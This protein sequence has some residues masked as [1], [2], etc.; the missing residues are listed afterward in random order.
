MDR[1]FFW[2]GSLFGLS[3]AWIPTFFGLDL[4]AAQK[5]EGYALAA[6]YMV[7]GIGLRVFRA[8]RQEKGE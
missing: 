4:T 1:Y 2:F 6:C 7:F 3:V 5:A 8:T